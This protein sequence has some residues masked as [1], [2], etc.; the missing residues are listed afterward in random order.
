MFDTHRPTALRALGLDLYNGSRRGTHILNVIGQIIR[1]SSR[2]KLQ[3]I[4][5]LGRRKLKTVQAT[6]EDESAFDRV[7]RMR[8]DYMRTMYRHRLKKYP[9]R[10]TLI[11]NE[12]Q[13]RFDKSLGWKGVAA[14]G[15]EVH[16]TPGDHWT[17]YLH[18]EELAKRLLG[19]LERAQAAGAERE[20]RSS[21]GA[22]MNKTDGLL[23]TATIASAL[24]STCSQ[25]L[26]NGEL[27][28]AR[29][30]DKPKCS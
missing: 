26:S 12:K 18:G 17:R 28:L 8:M 4:R 11:V 1:A 15:L 30:S 25:P 2:L 14:G 22:R 6:T 29:K 9:G 19:C 13:Y 7:Y 21:H 23:S 10:I 27:C 16:S 20:S 24:T 3:L 5:D